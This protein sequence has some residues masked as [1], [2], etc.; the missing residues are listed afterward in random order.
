M[1]LSTLRAGY[2]RP[3]WD[4][5]QGLWAGQGRRGGGGG[6]RV[7]QDRL[8]PLPAHLPPASPPSPSW[9]ARPP[10]PSPLTPTLCTHPP[11]LWRRAAPGNGLRRSGGR[12]RVSRSPTD[13]WLLGVG[14]GEPASREALV[15][16][17][18]PGPC[19]RNTALTA[20]T[21]QGGWPQAPGQCPQEGRGLC[22]QSHQCPRTGLLRGSQSNWGPPCL[23]WAERD[24]PGHGAGRRGAG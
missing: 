19:P 5:A 2:P 18:G 24:K 16:T 3:G 8:Q 9:P 12:A 6:P 20:R 10:L 15:A 22:H 11:G 23:R 7:S 21:Q 1:V 4:A 13:L 17:G 14:E